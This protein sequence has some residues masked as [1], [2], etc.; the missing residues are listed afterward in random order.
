MV[1][2][3]PWPFIQIRQTRWSRLFGRDELI[4]SQPGDRKTY[5]YQVQPDGSLKDRKL[6]AENGSDGMTLDQLGN[7]YLTSGGIHIYSPRGEKLGTIDVPESPSNLCF[8]RK[9]S[10]TL[11]VTARHG[12]YALKM[13]V[14][15]P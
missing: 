5:V 9:G 14:D 8:G 2:S 1:I 11:Y 6:I 3:G 7:L 15:G 4:A 13:Q 10:K 12:F